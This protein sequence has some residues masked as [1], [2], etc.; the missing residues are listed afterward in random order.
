M[1]FNLMTV[2]T[3]YSDFRA[4]IINA[5]EGMGRKEPSH[6]VGGNVSWYKHYGEQY[7]GFL[8]TKSRTTI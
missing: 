4:Q 3:I 6:T 8:K 7:A 5:G 2:V 1:S